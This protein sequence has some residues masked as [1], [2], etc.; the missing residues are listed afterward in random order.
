MSPFPIYASVV[1]PNYVQ[2]GWH[3]K[4]TRSVLL[5]NNKVYGM[6]VVFIM[7]GSSF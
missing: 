5:G 7:L 6:H 1:G 2:T 4:R 3:Y